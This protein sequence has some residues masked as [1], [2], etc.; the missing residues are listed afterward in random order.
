VIQEAWPFDRRPALVDVEIAGSERED[1]A[2]EVHRLVHA[3]RRG[4][5]PEVAAAVGREL[6]R[7]FNPRE[8]LGQGDLDERVALVVLEPDVVARPV[9]LDQVDLEQQRLADRVRHRVFQ[10]RDLVDDA[11]DQVDLTAGGLLLPVA[12]HPVPQALRLADVQNRPARVLHQVHAGPVRQSFEDG[13]DGS[14]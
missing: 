1:P 11:P 5:R 14:S 8:I 13:F 9:A 12:S 3:A 6:A 7:P 10:V 2:D 4:V